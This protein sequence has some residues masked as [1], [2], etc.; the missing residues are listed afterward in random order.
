MA[1]GPASSNFFFGQTLK[2]RVWLKPGNSYSLSWTWGDEPSGNINYTAHQGHLLL[3]FR[4]RDDGEEEWT[5]VKQ[6]VHFDYSQVHLGGQRQWL[7]CPSCNRRYR[8]LYGGARFYCRKCYRLKYRSQ[9]EDSA[10]RAVTRAQATRKRLGGLEGIDD[11]FHPNPKECTG[12]PIKD[13]RMPMKERPRAGTPC[14]WTSRPD[15]T[16]HNARAC[17]LAT[18]TP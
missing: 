10:L 11:P 2:K 16:A 6:T 12:R 17:T 4:V 9:G 15:F 8:I 7:V 1:V 13:L 3:D 14:F 5:P 18:W